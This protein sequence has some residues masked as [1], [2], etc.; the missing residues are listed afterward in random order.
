M[1]KNFILFLTFLSVTIADENTEEIVDYG[2]TSDAITGPDLIWVMVCAALVMFMQAGFALLESGMTR[3]KNSVNVL[4]K[5]YTDMAFG[6]LIFWCVGYGLMF[7]V[8]PSGYVG[9]SGFMPSELP[10]G[11]NAHFIFQLV[12]ASTAA[13]IMS[14]CE[15]HVCA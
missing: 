6:A 9:I 4:M 12:F 3:T 7:G 10:G 5:N 11:L 15:A 14:G 13:T 8:N 2:L 1:F